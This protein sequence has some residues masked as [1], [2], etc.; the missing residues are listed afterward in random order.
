MTAMPERAKSET[1]VD[2]A[3]EAALSTAK[4]FIPSV[5]GLFAV[6]G[7]IVQ[8]AHTGLIGRNVEFASGPGYVGAAADFVRDLP[9]ATIDGVLNFG[10]D[11]YLAGHGLELLAALVLVLASF[12]VRD[13]WRTGQ[14][15]ARFARF[16]PVG[17]LVLLLAWKF[18]SLD[19]PMTK[20]EGLVLG[21]GAEAVYVGQPTQWR[22]DPMRD[23]AQQ[24]MGA[25]L[26]GFLRRVIDARADCLYRSIALTR[27][28]KGAGVSPSLRAPTAMPCP[29][30]G[31]AGANLEQGEF[32]ARLFA[33]VIVGAL[34][35]VV[36][37]RRPVWVSAIGFVGLASLLTLPYAYGKLMVP[38]YFE[39]G[40]VLLADSLTKSRGLDPD[41][42]KDGAVDAIVLSRRGAEIDFLVMATGICPGKALPRQ[43]AKAGGNA[44][45]YKVARLWTIPNSQILSIREI[46]RQDVIAWKLQNEFACSSGAGSP[47]RHLEEEGQ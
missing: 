7:Y 32:V 23:K 9:T 16:L 13:R 29:V 25:R 4:W 22:S 11:G 42:K 2:G 44:E 18:V 38:S 1:P 37:R 10:G 8:T 17:A 14:C 41:A 35:F 45:T 28:G 6:V 12:A 31:A 30:D 27:S 34:A 40:R 26:P 36:A 20:V 39:V 47:G 43:P 15:A 33:C 5:T 19:A 3:W 21:T 46:H 24:G